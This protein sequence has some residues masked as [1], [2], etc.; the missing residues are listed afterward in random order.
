MAISFVSVQNG[1]AVYINALGTRVNCTATFVKDGVQ[2]TVPFTADASDPHPHAQ[3][4]WQ[5]LQNGDAGDIA[6]FDGGD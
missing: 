4:A 1:S 2:I 6:P 5:A 3:A